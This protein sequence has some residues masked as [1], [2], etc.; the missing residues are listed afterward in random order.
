[1]SE[2]TG[3][4]ECPNRGLSNARECRYWVQ[5]TV[6]GQLAERQ[7]QKKMYAALKLQEEQGNSAAMA[8]E[9]KAKMEVQFS[10]LK[11]DTF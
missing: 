4:G 3:S 6:E 10:V 11:Q 8:T 7:A 2:L 9:L 1:M 5:E